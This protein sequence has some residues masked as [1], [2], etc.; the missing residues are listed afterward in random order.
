MVIKYAKWLP[1]YICSCCGEHTSE[2]LSACPFC[3]SNMLVGKW[4]PGKEISREYFGDNLI[5][6]YYDRFTCSECGYIIDDH[7]YSSINYNYC[8][9]CGIKMCKEKEY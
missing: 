5:R 4:L 6:V 8:P 9:N 7:Y 2:Q 3:H 1:H